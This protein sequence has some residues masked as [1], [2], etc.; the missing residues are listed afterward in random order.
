M[1]ANRFIDLIK[2]IEKDSR[3]REQGFAIMYGTV[4]SA[5]P[6]Q[7]K[8]DNRFYLDEESLILT[9]NVIE[10]KISLSHTHTY[11]SGTTDAALESDITI[12]EALSVSEKV[13]LLRIEDGQRFVILDRLGG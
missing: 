4:V 10:K 3:S 8:V 7:I 11:A 6:L 1:S 2:T 9:T 5:D 13:M 12:I